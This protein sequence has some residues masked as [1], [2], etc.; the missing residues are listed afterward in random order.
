MMSNDTQYNQKNKV[1]TIQLRQDNPNMTLVAIGSIV[2]ITKERVRQ[3]LKKAGM[4]TRSTKEIYR[5]QPQHLKFNP[6]CPTC[7][8]PVPY[9]KTTYGGYHTKY[10]IGCSPGQILID[11]ICPY[12]DKSFQINKYRYL[13]RIKRIHAGS[14]KA[15]YCSHNCAINSYWD[16]VHKND[17]MPRAKRNTSSWVSFICG[18]C[19]NEKF[20][21]KQEYLQ[22]I[23]NSQTGMLFCD[24]TCLG[25][26]TRLINKKDNK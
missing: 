3:I 20:I 5:R 10:C 16:A 4:E 23:A 17:L 24:Y 15:I 12:C 8:K 14:Q 25:H 7:N 18:T 1:Y 9:H 19:D 22:R 21:R 11:V 2:G 6:S 13:L 26:W